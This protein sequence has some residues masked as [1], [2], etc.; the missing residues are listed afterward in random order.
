M[1]GL[2]LVYL[3]RPTVTNAAPAC[4]VTGNEMVTAGACRGDPERG[5]MGSPQI[6]QLSGIGPAPVAPRHRG[7]H[8]L[9]AWC[10]PAD[11]LQIRSV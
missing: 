8:E 11:H 3:P 9:R 6:L 10:Q 7:Q 4:G 5:R 1:A 2:K